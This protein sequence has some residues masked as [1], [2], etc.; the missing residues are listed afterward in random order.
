MDLAGKNAI[1]TGSN[2]GIGRATAEDLARRGAF[3][4]LANRS[5]E[6]T[7][8]V[9]GAIKA[10]GG[11]AE[12]LA[13]DLADLESVR[14][15]AQAL[16]ARGLPLHLLINNAG[17]AGAR[18]TTK[19][20]FELAFGTNHVGH[21]L[22]TRLLLPTLE[23]TKGARVVNVSSKAHYDAKKGIDWEAIRRPT[24]SLT[25]LD[26][27]SVSKLANVLFT[28]ELARRAPAVRAYSLHPGVIAS[29]AWRSVPWGI[30]HLMKAFMK[31][32]EE[33]ART[34]L[35]CA[36]SPELGAQTGRYYDACKE[37][38]PSKLADDEALARALWEKSAEW[39]GLPV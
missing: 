8:P 11:K 17:L 20:G 19:N 22:F 13:L 21:Y 7:R 14:A 26:E 24:A 33:G 6:K 31:S 15:A 37:R 28:K 4:F 16:L 9:L 27:Y 25:G 38:R 2:T 18:G 36:T 29:D 3:V 35:Y 39:T 32:N 1:V 34:T 12:F 23:K 30:R 10:A 5:E